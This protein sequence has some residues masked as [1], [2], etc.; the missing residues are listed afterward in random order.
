ML[1]SR[2]SA[3]IDSKDLL[4][5]SEP[6][7]E[8]WFQV[9]LRSVLRPLLVVDVSHAASGLWHVFHSTLEGL[10]EELPLAQQPD[11]A[12]LGSTERLPL[13]S[14][15]S[16][17][18]SLVSLNRGRGRV[19]SP[20]FESFGQQWPSRVVILASQMLHDLEDWQSHA[21]YPRVRLISPNPLNRDA[22]LLTDLASVRHE[23]EAPAAS[24]RISANNAIPFSWD[25]PA[26][27]TKAL[28]LRCQ[29]GAGSDVRIGFLSPES[30]LKVTAE[31]VQADGSTDPLGVSA[32][33]ALEPV[34]WSVLT[35]AELTILEAWR[36]RRPINCSHCETAHD[37]GEMCLA[38]KLFP[39]LKMIPPGGYAVLRLQMFQATFQPIC[40]SSFRLA[41][42]KVVTR[43]PSEPEPQLWRW[44][45]DCGWQLGEHSGLFLPLETPDRFL[46]AMP[47]LKERHG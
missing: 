9:R 38:S 33:E 45:P 24:V 31:L 39:S 34:G 40:C 27:Y 28:T 22:K 11:V 8:F 4:R 20:L 35:S 32:A 46:L 15:L 25:Q 14:F 43:S 29:P 10:A 23:L 1:T 18:D 36:A 13:R 21:M 5:V 37:P 41:A 42:D 3:R 19:I 44:N 17:L 30:K 26:Y 47:F 12:F 16:Q 6:V 2:C 7:N